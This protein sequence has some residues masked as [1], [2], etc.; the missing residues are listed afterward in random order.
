MRWRTKH[1]LKSSSCASSYPLC[2]CAKSLQSCPTLWDV[3]DCSLPG[4]S[5]HRIL[6]ARIVEWVAMPASRGSFPGIK[7]ASAA[8][9]GEFFTAET[10]GKMR[11]V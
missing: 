4:S 2:V 8:L 10:P 5:V 6:Q 9:A 1:E 3:I 7:L 11:H